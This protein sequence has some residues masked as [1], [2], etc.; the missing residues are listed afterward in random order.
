MSLL[1]LFSGSAIPVVGGDVECVHVAIAQNEKFTIS[2]S[3]VS[4][5]YRIQPRFTNSGYR[6]GVTI[7]KITC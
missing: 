5:A 7:A 2:D 6:I 1:F 3:A 4:N